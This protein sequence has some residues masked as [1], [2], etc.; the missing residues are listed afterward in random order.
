MRLEVQQTTLAQRR[1]IV[2]V[3]MLLRSQKLRQQMIARMVVKR[4]VP[5]R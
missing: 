3:A 5:I 2:Q 4:V 1:T